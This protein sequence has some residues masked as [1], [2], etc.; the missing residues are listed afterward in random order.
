MKTILFCCALVTAPL[1]LAVPADSLSMPEPASFLLLG[2]GL[3]G[4]GLAV[5]RRNRKR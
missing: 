5:W 1:C 3:A 4:I 2:A